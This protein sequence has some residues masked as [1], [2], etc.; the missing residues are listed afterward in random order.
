MSLK[1]PSVCHFTLPHRQLP[2]IIARERATSEERQLIDRA[3]AEGGNAHLDAVLEVI[4]RTGA[5]ATTAER[6]RAEASAALDQLVDLPDSEHREAL[7][8]LARYSHQRTR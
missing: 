3:V 6:A 8:T 1:S 7:A 2:L 4:R 5:L